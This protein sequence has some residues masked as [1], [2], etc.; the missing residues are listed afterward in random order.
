MGDALFDWACAG[1]VRPKFRA[2]GSSEQKYS[3]FASKTVEGGKL[4]LKRL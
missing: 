3:S 4:G 1:R 2:T